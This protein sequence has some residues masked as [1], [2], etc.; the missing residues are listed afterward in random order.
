MIIKSFLQI[1]NILKEIAIININASSL[2]KGVV[3]L[4]YLSILQDKQSISDF[5]RAH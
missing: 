2:K 5:Q 4:G 1:I 3:S